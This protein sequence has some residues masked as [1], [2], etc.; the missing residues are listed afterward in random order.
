MSF[1]F[2]IKSQAAQTKLRRV[3][4]RLN[5]VPN[6][7]YKYFVAKTPVRTGNA[8]RKTKLYNDTINANYPYAVPLDEGWSKQSP[9]G[10]SLPTF[11]Y[12]K[13]LVR[14]IFTLG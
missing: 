9:L 1:K 3:K 10:M 12:I 2:R 4:K 5:Q 8:R 7:G 14:R 13:K 6:R 11:L